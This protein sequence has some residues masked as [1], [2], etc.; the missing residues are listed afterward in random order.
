METKIIKCRL[1]L[2]H[3]QRHPRDIAASFHCHEASSLLHPFKQLALEPHR[4]HFKRNFLGS[5]VFAQAPERCMANEPLR[6][7][8]QAE[9]TERAS[10]LRQLFGKWAF[11]YAYFIEAAKQIR[12]N[13]VAK[14]PTRPA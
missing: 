1:P 6:R 3:P 8:A 4:L 10:R 11:R 14:T 9:Q 13:L 7:P 2:I 12:S 5:L